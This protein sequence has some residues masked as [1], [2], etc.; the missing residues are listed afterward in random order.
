MSVRPI[1]IERN[2]RSP[3]PT[4]RLSSASPSTVWQHVGFSLDAACG[5]NVGSSR[6]LN[7]AAQA[8]ASRLAEKTSGRGIE[9]ELVIDPFI[10]LINV[11][12]HR[13]I[14][15]LVA[16]G[17]NASAS[18]EPGPGTVVISTWWR[19]GFAG[20]DAVG[21]GGQVPDEIRASLLR[22][23][24]TTRVADWDTGLGLHE[25]SEAAAALEGRV[26]VFDPGEAAGIGFRFAISLSKGTQAGSP[27]AR[28]CLED[29][30]DRRPRL[31]VV[32]EEALAYT[33]GAHLAGGLHADAGLTRIEA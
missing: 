33:L 30:E 32:N 21:L 9:V 20:V 15:L 24:F 31:H 1:V 17:D 28:V 29:P 25:A 11:A 4:I 10:P 13:L 16:L 23:G 3:Q 5:G 19:N 26:E 14:P 12:A 6:D 2:P 18:V 27:E 22:P 7:R 8:A